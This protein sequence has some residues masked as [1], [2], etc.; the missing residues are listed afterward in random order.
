MCDVSFVNNTSKI[1]E[2]P[3]VTAINSCIEV[4]LTGQVCADS[5]GSKLYSGV[6]GQVDFIRGAALGSDGLGKPILAMPST[7]RHGESKIVKFIKEGTYLQQVR[8][9]EVN[10]RVIP[11]QEITALKTT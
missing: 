3:K 4:D 9:T 8:H 10:L 11:R 5:I 2:N 7:T 6:G 1:R